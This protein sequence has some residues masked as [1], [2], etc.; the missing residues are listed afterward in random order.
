[1]RFLRRKRDS[2]LKSPVE[3]VSHASG[4][5]SRL[6]SRQWQAVFQPELVEY[7]RLVDHAGERI[8][9]NDYL[10]LGFMFSIELA[11]A[12]DAKVENLG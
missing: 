12:R 5:R 10:L 2:L 1:M 9:T 11:A 8:L 6:R 7:Q 4:L 3:T